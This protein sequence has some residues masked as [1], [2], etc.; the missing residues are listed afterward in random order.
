[1]FQREKNHIAYLHGNIPPF[2]LSGHH[3]SGKKRDD[4]AQPHHTPEFS[5]EGDCAASTRKRKRED[6]K[7]DKLQPR[8]TVIQ[9]DFQR[10][11]IQ[12]TSPKL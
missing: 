8:N 5:V 6:L 12:T 4:Q 9:K 11:K 3:A 10:T 7:E 1:L 2:C